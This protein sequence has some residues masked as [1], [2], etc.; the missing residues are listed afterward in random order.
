LGFWNSGKGNV[1]SFNRAANLQAAAGSMVK[2]RGE[3]I[4]FAS[5]SAPGQGHRG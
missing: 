1:L 5:G 3:L 4:R 2:A